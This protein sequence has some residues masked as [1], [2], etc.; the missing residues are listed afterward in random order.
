MV[1]PSEDASELG[2][3]KEQLATANMRAARAEAEL[4][5]LR[6][7]L[8]DWSCQTCGGGPARLKA[9]SPV[10]SALTSCVAEFHPKAAAPPLPPSLAEA[11]SDSIA[12]E[13]SPVISATPP[14]DAEK[15]VVDAAAEEGGI[16]DGEDVE[17]DGSE[18]SSCEEISAEAP[19]EPDWL[20]ESEWLLT[21]STQPSGT[22]ATAGGGG[23]RGAESPA[24]GEGTD[25][26]SSAGPS[27]ATMKR[28]T[29]PKAAIRSACAPRSGICPRRSNG[30]QSPHSRGSMAT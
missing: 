10:G 28:Q 17:E 23:A 8:L 30:S 4:K 16:A 25:D 26:G 12:A 2:K 6:T 18:M 7:S 24:G 5:A 13:P 3:L 22:D 14:A 11:S 20:K 21:N 9:V 15:P 19:E 29:T 27:K 1:T